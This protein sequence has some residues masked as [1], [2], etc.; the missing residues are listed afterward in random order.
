MTNPSFKS[1]ATWRYVQF[2]LIFPLPQRSAVIADRGQSFSV[3][4]NDPGQ[5]TWKPGRWQNANK[6]RENDGPYGQRI[7]QRNDGKSITSNG[8]STERRFGLALSSAT[9]GQSIS[10]EK[11][12]GKW[13]ETLTDH[14]H[15]EISPSAHNRSIHGKNEMPDIYG[16]CPKRAGL[17]RTRFPVT[18]ENP[19]G[20]D[21]GNSV[22]LQAI[23]VLNYFEPR[24]SAFSDQ[25]GTESA[26]LVL[27]VCVQNCSGPQLRHISRSLST[28]RHGVADNF[29]DTHSPELESNE[30][31][32]Q[33][34]V[35]IAKA[36]M[37]HNVTTAVSGPQWTCDFRLRYNGQLKRESDSKTEENLEFQPRPFRIAV[38][39]PEDVPPQTPTKRSSSDSG[40]WS[41]NEWWAWQIATGADPYYE[42][43][44]E[45]THESLDRYKLAG[46]QNWTFL[47]MDSG[48][49]ITRNQFQTAVDLT[50]RVGDTQYLIFGATRYVDLAIL[51]LRN[52]IVLHQLHNRLTGLEPDLATKLANSDE[53]LNEN[54]ELRKQVDALASVERSF[55]T[56]RDKGWFT[57]V[58]GRRVDTELLLAIKNVI[59][60]NLVYNDFVD[61]LAFRQQVYNTQYQ[62]RQLV[63][64]DDRAKRSDRTNKVLGVVAAALGGP[65]IAEAFG[66]FD[67]PHI[68]SG[69]ATVGV[70]V[71]VWL[72]VSGSLRWIE[73][74]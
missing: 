26:F 68:W 61:E 58:P 16:K 62:Y 2:S 54:E 74:R 55:L 43:H 39:I 10:A 12:D 1:D 31:L 18:K 27:H 59:G 42:G 67:L 53:N 72:L 13:Y 44:P 11:E 57:S 51:T 52:S 71:F 5:L 40:A 46:L 30:S 60:V 21:G 50:E 32:L 36:L 69:I 35:Y 28:H 47:C 7:I 4:G 20:D 37:E 3:A 14:Y 17:P 6:F 9:R 65:G 33:H 48:V 56:F 22:Q 73:K 19:I 41:P 23:E 15:L 8:W 45:Q 29:T 49:G 34:F 66:L 38:A 24:D 63:S 70:C 25:K 64:S